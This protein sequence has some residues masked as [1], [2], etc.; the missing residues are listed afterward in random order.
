MK[1]GHLIKSVDPGSIAEE[2]ELEPGDVLLTIDGDEIEDIF[3]YEYKINS[4]EITLL[5]RK[6]NGE[7]WELDIVN[8][9]Q[10]LGITFENGLMSDYRSCRNKCIFCFIDQMP[11]G[12]RETLYFKDDDSRLSFLQGNYITLKN[13]TIEN[14]AAKL[15]QAVALHIEGDH[16]LVQNCRLL[17]NQD[18]VYT[19]RAGS[20]IAFYDCYIEGTTDFIFGPS[21]AWFENCEIHSKA[22]SYITAASSPAG[23]KYGYVFNTIPAMVLDAGHL[24]WFSPSILIYDIASSPGGTDFAYCKA[25]GIRADIYLGIPGKLYPKEAGTVIA[26]GIYEHVLATE[27]PSD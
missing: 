25:H 7:E 1:K 17:G 24:Q 6:K 2:M 12:M 18:T 27:T 8:E 21:L 13:I 11:P 20:R 4:E 9:Y 5:V 15:G 14:N 23:Q 22:D 16:I 19:G 26:S 3:D 10:D